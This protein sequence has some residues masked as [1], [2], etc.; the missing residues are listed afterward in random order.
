[1]KVE[2]QLPLGKVDP[3][4]RSA[5]KLDLS[6]VPR[7]AHE[8]EEMGFDGMTTGE[9]KTDPFIPLALGAT[10]T[11]R[12]T[13]TPTVA[14][15]FPRSPTVT[16]MMS[17]DL[18]TLSRG[19]FILGL[20]TQVKGH[21]ERR[22]G[23]LWH[24]PVP[25]LREYIRAVRA[26][27]D[28]WQ[29]GTPLK[30]QGQY[31]NL[32]LMVPLFNPGPI[33]HPRIPIQVAAVNKLISQLAGEVCDG[34]RPHPITTP[35]YISEVMLPSVAVGAQRAG[36]QLEDFQVAIS[37][38]VGVADNDEELASRLSDIRARIA[39]YASTRTYRP[40]FETHGWGGLV[41]QLHELSVK[42]RWDEMPSRVPDE[43]VETIAVVGAYDTIAQKILARYGAFATRI[44]FSL[45]VRTPADRERLCAVVRQLQRGEVGRP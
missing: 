44:K 11:E 2:A 27:W 14:I 22:Y 31:Y 19:R 30:V 37:P 18:Q 41:D 32:S 5:P 9:L 43:V 10:T 25:A 7:G 20:G 39:F 12:I 17:W 36:R 1:M 42:Q 8:I 29:N 34:I 38:L 13:L 28:C 40:V 6:S 3:G 26:V 23:M 15:A 33:E 16:A 45:P 24:P 4:L 35:K 21:I